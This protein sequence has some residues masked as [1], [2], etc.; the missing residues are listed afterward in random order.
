MNDTF[1]L[2]FVGCAVCAVAA[3]FVGRDPALQAAA[4]FNSKRA[5]AQAALNALE[6]VQTPQTLGD[7][8]T[9]RD[10]LR[11]QIVRVESE[12]GKR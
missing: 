4:D 6:N 1:F 2:A 7:A 3:L 12:L 5:A 10:A 11:D 9:A 8:K